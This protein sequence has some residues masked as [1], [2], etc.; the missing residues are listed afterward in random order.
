MHFCSATCA[1]GPG[2]GPSTSTVSLYSAA[3]ALRCSYG[4]LWAYRAILAAPSFQ[5]NIQSA[6]GNT[7]LAIAARYG[8]VAV[9]KYL[10]AHKEIQVNF[11]WLANPLVTAC[12]EGHLK[13]PSLAP[14]HRSKPADLQ[15]HMTAIS[16]TVLYGCLFSRTNSIET[17][18]QS[19]FEKESVTHF[20]GFVLL[21]CFQITL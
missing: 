16:L 13:V 5:A 20:L 18:K 8:R 10:C 21:N 15:L 9:V 3:T 19:T 4:S 7:A 6:K 11:G 12:Y 14:R 1:R 17:N 2:E